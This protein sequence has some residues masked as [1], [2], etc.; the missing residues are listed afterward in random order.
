M[1]NSNRV[2]MMAM[3]ITEMQMAQNTMDSTRMTRKKEK[4]S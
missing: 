2:I 1:D 3:D 4:E